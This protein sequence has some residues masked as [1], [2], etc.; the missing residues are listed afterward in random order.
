M[1]IYI[2][3]I[4]NFLHK[5]YDST[6]DRSKGCEGVTEIIRRELTGT[7]IWTVYRT[8][9][10]KKKDHN[11]EDLGRQKDEV[12]MN[13]EDPDDVLVVRPVREGSMGPLTETEI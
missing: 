1:F 6:D 9:K 10:I 2:Y 13:N 11:T 8:V 7:Q 3:I 12:N 4:Y 5:I